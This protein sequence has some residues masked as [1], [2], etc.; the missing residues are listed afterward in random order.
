ME[1]TEILAEGAICTDL[2]AE[3][4]DEAIRA[5][6]S[7]LVEVGELE[8]GKLEPILQA[9]LER[10]ALGSTA[11]GRGVAVPHARVGELDRTVMALGLSDTG[12]EFNALDGEAVHEIF[13]VVGPVEGADEYLGALQAIGRLIQSQD[14]RRF[15]SR[16]RTGRDVLDLMA[17]MGA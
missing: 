6:L 9:I 17:E 10:E 2:E 16:A 12:V 3:G 8:G 5:L 4:R 1:F 11:I 15:L 14:F 7:R 13:L